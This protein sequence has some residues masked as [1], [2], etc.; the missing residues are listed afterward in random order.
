[1]EQQYMDRHR[2]STIARCLGFGIF[3]GLLPIPASGQPVR[4]QTQYTQIYYEDFEGSHPGTLLASPSIPPGQINSAVFTTDASL[5]IA[6]KTSARIGWFGQ[7][8]TVPS[9]LPLVGNATYIVEFQYHILNFGTAFDILHLDLQPVGTTDPALQVNFAHMGLNVPAS[10]TFSAGGLLGSAANYVLTIASQQQ[11]DI[12]IDNL[13]VYRQDAVSTSTTP[14]TWARLETLPF[15]R[16]GK[17][18]GGTYNGYSATAPSGSPYTLD[19]IERAMAFFDVAFGVPVIAQTQLPQEIRRAR[20]LNPNAVILPYRLAEEQESNPAAMGLTNNS[21]VSLDYQFLQS[22]PPE[23]YLRDSKG[24]IVFEQGWP[25]L[26][27]MNVSSYAPA[28]N[29]YSYTASVVNW[30]NTAIFPSGE[31]DGIFFD[32]LL[33]EI[34]PNIPNYTNPALID[35]DIER[36]GKRASPAQVSE[37]GRSGDTSLLK[38]LRQSNGDRQLIMGNALPGAS[39]LDAYVNGFLCECANYRWNSAGTTDFSPMGWRTSFDAYRGY[40]ATT[41]R[42]RANAFEGCGAVYGFPGTTALQYPLPTAADIV[43]HRFTMSTA[44]LGDGFYVFDLHGMMGPPLWYDEYSVDST[45]TAVQDTAKKGYLGQALSDATELANAGTVLLGE[46]FEGATLPVSLKSGAAPGTTVAISQDPGEVIGGSGSLVLSNPNHT[47]TGGVSVS[48]NPQV[49][50]FTAGNSYLLTFDWRIIETVDTV[51]G[52]AISTNPNQPLDVYSA[53]GKVAGDHGT[54]NVPFVIPSSGQWS[55]SIYLVNGGK[56]AIDNIQITPGGAGPWRRDF[57]NGFTLVN[58]FR[59]PHTFTA[60]DLAG[61][62]KRGGIHRIKGTQAPDVNNGQPVTGGLTLGAFDAIILLA[63]HIDAARPSATRPAIKPNGVI[64]A[65]AFGAF[66]STA[67]GSWIEIYGSILAA[68]TRS[69]YG[70]DFDG[71]SAPTSLDG[72]SVLVGGRPAYISYVSPTQI[73]ALVPSDAAL[74]PMQVIVSGPAGSS[75]P[76]V[77]TVQATQPGLLAP[78]SFQVNGKQYAGALFPD[79]QTFVLPSGAIPGALSRPAKPGETIVLY[80]VGFGPVTPNIRAG[81]LAGVSTTLSNPI[82]ILVGNTPAALTYYGLAPTLTG[83]YQFNIV[84]PDV[85][86]GAAVPLTYRLGGVAG[87]QTLYIAVQ[88]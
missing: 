8:R 80:G 58:P 33:G 23:W 28:V 86:D 7:I 55:V 41:R 83:I 22:V 34:N 17:Y 78:A 61:S 84:V 30:L 18:Q 69:W 45:G 43:S 75:D 54:A 64:S 42:P 59:Q 62:L 46:A 88:R 87:T 10:G 4:F 38:Q 16:L 67:P 26:Y 57:E 56:A 29:G 85:P 81:T 1:M 44:L 36:T 65:G 66:S 15:P 9:A 6:G 60:A 20:L 14:A 13:A 47:A 5:V 32:N 73:N 53:P 19:Y 24:N 74:G 11:T 51:L 37:M 49:V 52:A 72:V 31:W 79:G 3:L 50:Q 71:N 40:E 25:S 82:Q 35:V 48:T 2:R 39:G 21:N 12:V 68:T 76:Y 77:I 27:L 63:D 70:A